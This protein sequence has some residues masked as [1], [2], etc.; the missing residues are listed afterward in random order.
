MF[1]PAGCVRFSDLTSRKSERESREGRTKQRD[2]NELEYISFHR[3]AGLKVEQFDFD[4][5]E[6]VICE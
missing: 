2:D 6:R 4:L 1:R 5:G 3:Y